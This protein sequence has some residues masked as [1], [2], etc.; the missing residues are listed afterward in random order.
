MIIKGRMNEETDEFEV[1]LNNK[2]VK[3]N[4]GNWDFVKERL[5]Y[6]FLLDLCYRAAEPFN[7][8]AINELNKR[9]KNDLD[10][11]SLWMLFIKGGRLIGDMA[12]NEI[13]ASSGTR[14]NLPTYLNR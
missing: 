13:F 11:K 12:M 8:K 4:D 5:S 1:F 3:L 14:Y 10:L 7:E 2:W 9:M 6:E